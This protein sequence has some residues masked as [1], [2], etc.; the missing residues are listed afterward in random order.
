[1][2]DN[3]IESQ[4]VQKLAEWLEIV[5]SEEM[6]FQKPQENMHLCALL[7]FPCQLKFYLNMLSL[8]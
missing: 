8:I 4:K 6:P 1:M 3:E 2:R 5:T 7:W